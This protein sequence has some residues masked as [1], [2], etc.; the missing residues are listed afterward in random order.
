MERSGPHHWQH[1]RQCAITMVGLVR[2]V[3]WRRGA[4]VERSGAEQSR[5][6]QSRPGQARP[7]Q[8]DFMRGRGNADGE[9]SKG[10]RASGS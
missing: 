9:A 2:I 8:I 6:E 7:G 1:R 3:K 10:I 5:A 4:E